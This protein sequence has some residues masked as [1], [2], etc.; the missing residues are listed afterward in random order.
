LETRQQVAAF[1]P[2]INANCQ[3]YVVNGSAFYTLP[4]P[5]GAVELN[6]ASLTITADGKANYTVTITNPNDETLEIDLVQFF[7]DANNDGIPAFPD[8]LLYTIGD[9]NIVMAPGAT[10]T[11]PINGFSAPDSLCNILAVLPALTNCICPVNPVPVT[12]ISV[13]YAAAI[14]CPEESAPLGVPAMSGHNYSWSSAST[15]PCT[16][17]PQLLFTPPGPGN[18]QLSLTDAGPGCTVLHE[19]HVQAYE[20]P[21]LQT[22]NTVVCTGQTVTLQ[23]TQAVSWNWQGPGISNPAAPTQTFAASQSAVYFVTATN[24]E[25]CMLTDSVLITALPIDSTNLGTLR[26]CEGT[27]VDIFGTMT[28]IPGLYTQM[29][30]NAAGCDSLLYLTLETTPNTEEV[31]SRCPPDTVLIFN[32]PVTEAGIYCQTFTSSLGCDSMHCVVLQDYPIPILPDPDTFFIS[33]GNSIVLPG[34]A[35]YAAYLWTPADSLSCTTCQSPIASPADTMEYKLMLTTTD[36]CLDTVVYRVVPL[37]PCNP[38]H[39]RIPNAF[40]PD[41]DGNNDVFAVVPYEGLEVISRL[42]I[43]NRWGQK[44][45]EASGQNAAWDGTTFG[46][47]APSDVYIWL[48]EVLCD[49]ERK[50]RKGDVT[51]LR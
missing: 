23:T 49:G 13:E 15:L 25:G 14:L 24:A 47:P 41:G 45:Y 12:N 19:Y 17:C 4:E 11:V 22:G 27:P 9:L 31:V 48:L 18:Y 29:L 32:E 21:V 34:P 7:Y 26:T 46:D 6:A 8:E 39:I 38:A 33:Q 35:G 1:C 37:P 44:V 50:V 3:V 30:T 20:A 51:V 40:T 5:S 2:T 16:D 28:D 10:V 36:G 42:T 43:Y